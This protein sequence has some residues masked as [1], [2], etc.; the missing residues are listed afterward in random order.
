MKGRVKKDE[1]LPV[2]TDIKQLFLIS[3]YSQTHMTY[4]SWGL[5]APAP[6]PRGREWHARW[7]VLSALAVIA[8]PFNSQKHT[9]VSE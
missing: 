2:D 4:F 9:C 6:P 3:F 1:L 8:L 5:S 7:S